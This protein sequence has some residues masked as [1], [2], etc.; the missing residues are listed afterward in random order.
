MFPKSPLKAERAFVIRCNLSS[1][2]HNSR[3]NLAS[4]L[5]CTHT[6]T[7]TDLDTHTPTTLMHSSQEFSTSKS[8]FLFLFFIFLLEESLWNT[9]SSQRWTAEITDEQIWAS[10]AGMAAKVNAP[11]L[12]YYSNS[13][14]SLLQKQEGA[15]VCYRTRVWWYEY[16]SQTVLVQDTGFGMPLPRFGTSCDPNSY[17]QNSPRLSCYSQ[18]A[19][20]IDKV[21]FGKWGPVVSS[22]GTC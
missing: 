21:M 12:K 2:S 10:H 22:A 3:P 7:L 6:C 20:R 13:Y 5:P 8:V 19:L 4:R 9:A 16:F 1:P 15:E 17:C 14:M 11:T 18:R